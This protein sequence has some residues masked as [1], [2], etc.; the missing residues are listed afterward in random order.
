MELNE[1]KGAGADSTGSEKPEER[2]GASEASNDLGSGETDTEAQADVDEYRA[3]VV[4]EIVEDE[5]EVE[6]EA[7]SEQYPPHY[8]P[9]GPLDQNQSLLRR[10]SPYL[11]VAGLLLIARIVIYSMRR[12]KR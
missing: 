10:L 1:E 11:T 7:V 8:V 5:A 3:E 2:A 4:A 12:R 6:K 9:T